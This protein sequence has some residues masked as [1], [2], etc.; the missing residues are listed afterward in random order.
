MGKMIK[1]I[2]II[3]YFMGLLC[4]FNEV[5]RGKDV[6]QALALSKCSLNSS[7]SSN[8]GFTLHAATHT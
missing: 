6:R 3:P 7:P 8:P 2:I 4:G 1:V 5:F